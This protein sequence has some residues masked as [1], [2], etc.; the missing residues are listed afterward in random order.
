MVASMRVWFAACVLAVGDP[1]PTMPPRTATW[2][3]MSRDVFRTEWILPEGLPVDAEEGSGPAWDLSVRMPELARLVVAPAERDPG[4]PRCLGDMVRDV[5]AERAAGRD[6]R[7][8]I[9]RT[10]AAQPEL[11]A[12]LEPC[13]EALLFDTGVTGKSWDP[14]DHT[15][16]DGFFF[17]RPLTIAKL[18]AQ[19]WKG[20]EGS[21]RIQ[22]AAQLLHA[23]FEAIKA[24]ENDFPAYKRR[25]GNTYEEIHPVEGSYVRGTD[26]RGKPFAALK[27]YFEADLPFPFS[28]YK[29][30]LRILS[31]TDAHGDFVCD[32]FSPSKDFLWMAGR[33]VFVPVRDSGGAWQATLMVRWF[34]FDMRGVPDGDSDRCAALRAGAGALKRDAQALF[35]RRAG[36]PRTV[37]GVTPPFDVL[38][39]K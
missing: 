29:C 26:E 27:L 12:A 10:R 36:P 7:A 8:V 30:D 20:C 2:E 11:W 16:D 18:A 21:Q 15:K 13:A 3:E 38:G 1:V 33:D 32:I 9:A 22:Q 39:R 31:R 17:A 25:P 34:G 23:D 19:P 35:E 28:S 5:R 24:A 6:G 37:E 4:A 14:D